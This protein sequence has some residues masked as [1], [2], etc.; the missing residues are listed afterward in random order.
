M[1]KLLYFI[2]MEVVGLNVGGNLM[3]AG[4]HKIDGTS[5]T[6]APATCNF[7][8]AGGKTMKKL[9]IINVILFQYCYFSTAQTVFN[10]LYHPDPVANRA[11]AVIQTSDGGYLMS[12]TLDNVNIMGAI[13]LNHLG[14]TLWNFIYDLGTGSPADYIETSVET[15]DGNY[16]IGG[17]T[18]VL[19]AV[20]SDAFLIK[21]NNSGDTL[22]VKTYG[23]VPRSERCYN[24]KQT[25]DGG[26][27]F[28]GWRYNSNGTTSDVYLVKTDSLGNQQ[29]E[30][31]FGGVNYEFGN[32]I[33]ITS[34]GGY[35]I[36]GTTYSYGVGQ[37][38]MYLVKTDS[39]GNMLWQKT[40]GGN[41]QDYGNSI[42]KAN[43]GG[44]VLAGATYISTD[45]VAGYLVKTDTSGV[46]QWEKRYR[47]P[48]KEEE[49]NS[50]KQ[51]QNGD[52]VVCGDA[53]GDTL[54]YTYYGIAKKL[55][56]NGS[57]IW[58][59]QYEYFS[60]LNTQHYFYTMD[61]CHDGGFIMAGMTIDA[62]G[63][64]TPANAMWLVKTDCMGN[65]NL[66]DSVSCQVNLGIIENKKEI[67]NLEIYPNPATGIFTIHS[68]GNKIKEI[69]VTNILGQE[70]ITTTSQTIN[71][72]NQPNGIYFVRVQTEK[73][74]TTRKLVKQ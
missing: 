56:A 42:I 1:M 31:T 13:K 9:F 47:G 62:T 34:E 46:V 6:L 44:Y 54:N 4:C 28:C 23:L 41:L 69:K 51:L 63:G 57:A 18:G 19:S 61:T 29:W 64:T 12:G 30:K 20:N 16:I 74:I 15:R 70:I 7:T 27:I 67:E 73:G 59:K 55:D 11:N 35:L 53:Q 25:S 8:R 10:N 39:L 72:I 5:G 50:V 38:N 14:D 36:F 60:I 40:Y 24:V 71:L 43:D 52:L 58:E 3:V 32:S 65:D 22:W 37:Y 17:T 2:L 21:L 26:F 33:E 66:W 68:E 49:F 45:S 48:A